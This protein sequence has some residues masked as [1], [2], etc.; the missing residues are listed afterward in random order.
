MMQ[1]VYSEWLADIASFCV[2]S[3]GLAKRGIVV[4]VRFVVT[5]F[6]GGELLLVQ[7]DVREATYVDMKATLPIGSLCKHGVHRCVA[8]DRITSP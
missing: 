2:R 5:V 7:C 8:P 6:P 3:D 4:S 1:R